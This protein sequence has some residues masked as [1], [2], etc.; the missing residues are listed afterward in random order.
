MHVRVGVCDSALDCVHGV[1][2]RE[3]HNSLGGT[4]IRDEGTERA[5]AGLIAANPDVVLIDLQGVD[6]SPYVDVLDVLDKLRDNS[7]M[8]AHKESRSS[9]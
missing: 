8:L 6:L 2:H 4:A 5:F 3:L 9:E 1:A 7:V